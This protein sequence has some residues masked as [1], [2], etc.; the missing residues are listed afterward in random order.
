[1]N[2]KDVMYVFDAKN[3]T[4]GKDVVVV[5]DGSEIEEREDALVLHYADNF[6]QY[7]AENINE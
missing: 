1:M 6:E 3:T 7:I 4:I 2:T 5:K